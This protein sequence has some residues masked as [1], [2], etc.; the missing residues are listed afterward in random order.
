[1][2]AEHDDDVAALRRVGA[3][4]AEAR[5]AVLAAVAPG[6][7]TA[8]L[9]SIGREVLRAH[10]ARSAPRLAYGFPG[11]CC[12]GINDRVAHGIPS[13][14]AVLRDGDLVNVDVSAELDGYWGDTGASVGVGSLPPAHRALLEATRAA[15]REGMRVARAGRPLRHIGRAVSRSARRAG[16]SVIADL[17]GHGVGRGIHE[18]PTVSNVEDP[19]NR[20]VLHEG[21][22]LAIEPFLT[23]G[24]PRIVEDADGWTLRTVD[25]SVAAQFEHSIIVTAGEPIVL[26]AS[27][28]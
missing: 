9:D 23:A 7:S 10:G 13:A 21:L 6:V 2:T 11:S 14:L 5:D 28:A 20:T 19:R 3:V 22:V 26:T 15:Q 24:V 8:E 16:F 4:V 18:E 12:I 25:G 17:A 27:A 1:M